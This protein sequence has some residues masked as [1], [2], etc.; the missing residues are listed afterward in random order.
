[1]ANSARHRLLRGRNGA[2]A[3]TYGFMVGLVALVGI[4]G[5]TL[6]GRS[7]SDVMCNVAGYD[8]SVPDCAD[9]AEPVLISPG[10]T[11]AVRLTA[12]TVPGTYSATVDVGGVS[13]TFS[14][15]ADAPS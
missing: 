3:P 11:L 10:Q 6:L 7:V 5:V 2:T 9:L 4:G 13:D 1:M 12:G 8:G 14:V 15:E